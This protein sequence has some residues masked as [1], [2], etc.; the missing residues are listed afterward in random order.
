MHTQKLAACITA[1]AFDLFSGHQQ[2]SIVG[3]AL[4]M[5]SKHLNLKPKTAK[6][7]GALVGMGEA[8]LKHLAKKMEAQAHVLFS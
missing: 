5:A 6:E 4:L 7:I 2:L 3:A 1:K 8:T